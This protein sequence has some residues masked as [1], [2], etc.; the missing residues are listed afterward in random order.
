MCGGLPVEPVVVKLTRREFNETVRAIRRRRGRRRLQW[1]AVYLAG[2][3]AVVAALGGW[4]ALVSMAIIFVVTYG[5]LWILFPIL[6]TSRTTAYTFDEDGI[7]S[8]RG[9]RYAWIDVTDV[10]QTDDLLLVWCGRRICIVPKRC[11]PSP[12]HAAAVKAFGQF[13]SL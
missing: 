9:S 2:S 10:V 8:T 7:T 5:I 13:Q 11:L 6:V 12:E 4:L 3:A 1:F